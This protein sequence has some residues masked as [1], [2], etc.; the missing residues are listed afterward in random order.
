MAPTAGTMGGFER[1]LERDRI[2]QALVGA[3]PELADRIEIDDGN[4][5]MKI[6]APQGG[7]VVIAKASRGGVAR[8]VIA[9]PGA[10]APAVHEPN[11]MGD[12]PKIVGAAL[13]LEE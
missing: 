12:Y 2:H 7:F 3:Y 10:S 9:V 6:P 8:W 11:G 13:G 5:M 4:P 1:F